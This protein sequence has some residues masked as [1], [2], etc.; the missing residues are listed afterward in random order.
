MSA[1]FIG[2]RA[3][4]S[5]RFHHKVVSGQNPPLELRTRLRSGGFARPRALVVASTRSNAALAFRDRTRD[6][7]A[8][9]GDFASMAESTSALLGRSLP[10]Q[11]RVMQADARVKQHSYRHSRTVRKHAFHCS[12]CMY[13]Y[14][15]SPCSEQRLTAPAPETR[16]RS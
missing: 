14:R 9:D 10:A 7:L 2:L 6:K 1:M 15:M 5:L 13:A 3:C 8:A 12:T 11:N 4:D 16:S